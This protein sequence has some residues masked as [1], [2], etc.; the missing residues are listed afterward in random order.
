VSVSWARRDRTVPAGPGGH[1]RAVQYSATA[2]TVTLFAVILALGLPLRTTAAPLG[3]V[4][5]Q[6]AAAPDVA[7]AMLDSWAAVPRA[8]ILWAHGLD[9]LLPFAY[10]LAL[11]MAVTR[12]GARSVVAVPAAQLAVG[13]V[14]AAA[15]ADQVE[16]VAMAVTLLMGPRWGS[17]LVTLAA[18]T[19]KFTTLLIALV[20][21]AITLRRA[22]EAV[23]A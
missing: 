11:G 3:I 7:D 15:V 22:R 17:V 6:L 21:L 13:A 23:I 2:A 4:S 5:L 16:N 1:R 19:V 8:R 20:A 18:A 14:I 9:L 12:A 10:A